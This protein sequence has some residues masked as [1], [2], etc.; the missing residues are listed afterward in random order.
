M[1]H[2][3]ACREICGAWEIERRP[4]AASRGKSDRRTAAP[5]FVATYR[6]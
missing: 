5:T 1:W 2:K 3:G 4:R 6:T